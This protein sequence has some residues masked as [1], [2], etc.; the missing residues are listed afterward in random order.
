MLLMD[1]AGDTLTA[2]LAQARGTSSPRPSALDLLW[3][4]LADMR[5]T[6]SPLS[7]G[8]WPA[9]QPTRSPTVGTHPGWIRVVSRCSSLGHTP[10][11]CEPPP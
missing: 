8:F 6:S 4:L 1:I 7:A 3:T 11:I 2:L 10:Q 9:S 5:S